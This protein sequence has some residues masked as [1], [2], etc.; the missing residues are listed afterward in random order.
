[1]TFYYMTLKLFIFYTVNAVH[2]N[3]NFKYY[4]KIISLHEPH[5]HDTSLSGIKEREN[6]KN[7]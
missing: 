3:S 2:F 5:N 6:L 1:M 4:I 7:D